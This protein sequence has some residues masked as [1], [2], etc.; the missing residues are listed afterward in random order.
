MK[1]ICAIYSNSSSSGRII[2]LN[3]EHRNSPSPVMLHSPL[4]SDKPPDQP[5]CAVHW[6]PC[7]SNSGKG[8]AELEISALPNV[9]VPLREFTVRVYSLIKSHNNYL[10]LASFCDC[11]EAEFGSLL[12]VGE[13][14]GVPLEHMVTCVPGI[15]LVQN[16]GTAVK[17]LT[18]SDNAFINNGGVGFEEWRNDSSSGDNAGKCGSSSSLSHNVALFSR[19]LVDLLKTFPRCMMS[20]N[21]FI[22]SY[23]HHFGRQCRVA[24]YGYTKLID[25]LEALPLVVQVRFIVDVHYCVFRR[26]MQ[27]VEP[28]R[29]F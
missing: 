9:F 28:D 20:F 4:D 11:Y 29:S 16:T 5:Y 2:S 25:L 27:T 8:W 3:P 24:D 1:E 14:D 6:K 18:T 7:K 12:D 19:E 15:E 23:H 17:Y 10:L 22:P 26:I 21:R 13:E